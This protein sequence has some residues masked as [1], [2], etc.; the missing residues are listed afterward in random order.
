MGRRRIRREMLA[1]E[2]TSRKLADGT[3]IQV[4]TILRKHRKDAEADA[5]RQ[6]CP[7]VIEIWDHNIGDMANNNG[8]PVS[9][10]A[11]QPVFPTKP[12]IMARS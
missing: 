2:L 11:S 9:K 3:P 12:H 1:K 7:F 4:I 8:A 5:Q 6:D 10:E